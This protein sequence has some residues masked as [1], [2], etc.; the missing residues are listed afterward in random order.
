[1]QNKTKAHLAL[2][3]TNIKNS[4]DSICIS[5]SDE[6]SLNNFYYPI[7]FYCGAAGILKLRY[8]A[9][10]SKGREIAT[11]VAMVC[12]ES[13]DYKYVQT[14]F[15]NKENSQGTV[16]FKIPASGHY[17]LYLSQYNSTHIKYVIYPGSNLF[18][19]N[20]KSILMNGLIM[21]DNSDINYQNKYLAINTN[22]SELTWS[23]LYPGIDNTSS[24]YTVSGKPISIQSD[25][26]KLYNKAKL[27]STKSTQFIFYKSSVYRWPP[28]LKYNL[29]CYFFF[30]YPLK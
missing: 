15:V 5:T 22:D 26:E 10:E 25:K 1:M 20:K 2:L 9:S 12:V 30:K 18:F 13:D 24:L 28:V 27:P 29:P 6:I 7:E 4:A 21:Q 17:K 14:F 8:E 19:H 3:A 23:N 11:K 16:T